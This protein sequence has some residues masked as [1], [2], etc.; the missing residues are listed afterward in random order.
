MEILETQKL[1]FN[2]ENMVKFRAGEK[3]I[4]NY[5]KEVTDIVE[6]LLD[7]KFKDAKKKAQVLPL[8]LESVRNYIHN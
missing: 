5:L 6:P 8:K 7:M 2:E 3:Y 1:T 4:L